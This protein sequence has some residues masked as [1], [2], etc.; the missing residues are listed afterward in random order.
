M[1]R[2]HARG[3]SLLELMVVITVIAILVGLA[4]PSYRSWMA[5]TRVRSAAESIQNGLRTARNEAAQ[6]GTNV[7]FEIT[8]TD[9]AWQVC[10]LAD[11]KTTCADGGTLITQHTAG[12]TGG[13]VLTGATDAA[14]LSDFDEITGGIPAGITFGAMARPLSA[15]Y[16]NTALLRIDATSTAPDARRLVTTISAGGSIQMC[17]AALDK[18]VAATGCVKA[19]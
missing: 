19:Q 12:D 13:V 4:V 11:T 2:R 17:D 7:R 15:D 1:M 5:N 14:K 6:R 18:G 16:N 3:F 10:Q 9:S 8:S